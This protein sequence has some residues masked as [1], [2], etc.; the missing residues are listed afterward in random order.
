[1]QL[2]SRLKSLARNLLHKPAI[3]SELDEELQTYA[4]QLTEEKIADGISPAEARRTTLA[5]LGGIE[6]VKQSVRDRRTG[7]TLEL[8][9]QDVRYAFRQLN[10]NRAFTLTA[11]LTLALGIGATT[12]IFSAV[13]ALLLRPLPYPSADR[14]MAVTPSRS[15]FDGDSLISPDFM[16]A[17]SGIKSFSD[18]AGYN[19]WIENLTGIGGP[20][21][22]NCTNITANFLPIFGVVP[23]FGRLF[24]QDEDR[25]GGSKVVILSDRLWR[26]YFHADPRI[27]GKSLDLNGTQQTVVG[28][29]PR[30]FFFPDLA[31]DPDLYVPADLSRDTV[32]SVEKPVKIVH[33]FARLRAGVSIQQAQ[34]E[35]QTFYTARAHK[36]PREIAP[37][38]ASTHV[39][40]EPLQRHIAGDNREPLFILLACVAAVLFIA[41]AN[42]ANLQLARAVSR[43]HETALRGALGAS[44][45]RLIRQFLLESLLLSSLAAACGL[46]IAGAITALVRQTGTLDTS[47]TPSRIAQ[48]LQ[49][50]FGKLSASIYIDGWVFAFTIGLALVTTLLFGLAP[51]ISGSRADFRTALQSAAMRLT[52][53]REQ[54]LLGHSLLIIEVAIAVVLLASAGLLVRSFVNVMQYDSSFDPSDTLTGTT[55]LVGPH[56]EHPGEHGMPDSSPDN[57]RNFIQNVLP[58]LQS[59]PGIKAAA[60]ASALPLGWV[61]G[62][63]ISFGSPTPPPPIGARKVVPVISITSDYFEVVRSAI[64]QGRPFTVDDTSTSPPVAIVNRA[65]AHHYFSDNALGRQFNRFVGDNLFAPVTIV[66]IA[67][68]VRHNGLEQAVQPEFYVPESQVPSYSVNIALRS[69]ADPT[70]LA[71]AMRKA[72]LAVDPQQPLFDIETMDQRVSDQVAQRRLIMLLIACFAALAVILSA[73][74]V[75]GVFAYSVSQRTQEMGIRLA[76][77]A[78]RRRLL[79]LIIAQAARLIA[80]GGILGIVAALLLSR[81]LT[82]MLVG[83]KPHDAL[84]FSLA[85]LLMTAIALLAS[86]IPASHAACTDLVSVLHTE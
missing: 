20:L 27:I 60:I 46:I 66:G 70:L 28:V 78:S 12:A 54:R 19:N 55:L 52:Q 40:V 44:R 82:S 77:G 85:W 58:R 53:A 13:Y 23:Q 71:N 50:P 25:P 63:A 76:L 73:V 68:D 16:A 30:S 83:V 80:A 22:V 2:W 5:E 33:A 64:L 26:N 42:V 69:T 49:L 36:S 81:A 61:D 10:R 18:L 38:Y 9:W 31:L 24:T 48:F 57:I 7:I 29:L 3:E 8:L 59:L 62:T 84:S 39:I 45:L 11:V 17:Q 86:T 4:A 32:L 6:Q 14:L 1:M 47:Q 51:A 41:C 43:R 21:R 37:Y 56:Y 75:Y 74:G 72:V 34:A 79:G 35:L 15:G 65:F 67:Q